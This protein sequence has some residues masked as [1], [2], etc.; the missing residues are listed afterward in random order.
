MVSIIEV[1]KAFVGDPAYYKWKRDK[2]QPWIIVERSVDKIKRLGSVLSTGDNLRTYWGDGD[3]RNNSKFT[4]LHMSDNEVESIKFDEYKKMF[5]AAEVMKHIQRTNPNIDQKRL[6]NMV[7]KE[8]INNTMKTLNA[9]VKKAIEDSVARQ[10]AAYGIDE[11]GRGRIN[12]ADAAVYIRPALY[13][14]IV[15]AVGEWSPEVERAFDL[16]ESPDESWLSDPK[17]YAQ[18]IETLI[19]PLKMVYFGNHELTKLGLNVPVFDKMAI[20]PMFRVMAKADNYHLYNRM[21]NEELGAI[22][23]LTFESAVKVGGR[24]KFKPYK[25][26]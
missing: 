4:V 20:F 1:E 11:N 24:K 12:Q 10:I 26:A 13:K 2:K 3:P 14:R 25:D 23:M 9:K 7:S 22:D 8:N 6:V 19:K 5:T 16:L 17:L 21:N 18:A 15:Q